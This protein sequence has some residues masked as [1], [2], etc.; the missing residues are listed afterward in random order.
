[1]IA[2]D[3]LDLFSIVNCESFIQYIPLVL[4]CFTNLR[5]SFHEREGVWTLSTV[6]NLYFARVKDTLMRRMI[7]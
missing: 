1:V 2:N 4:N 7:M 6:I 3:A 5:H